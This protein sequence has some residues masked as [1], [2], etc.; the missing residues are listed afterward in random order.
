MQNRFLKN[1]SANTVQLIINQLFG[2]MIFYAL[3]KWFDKNTFGNINWALAVLLTAFTILSFGID[4]VIVQKIAAGEDK[5]TIFSAY[6]FHVI[7][8]GIFF[9]AILLL[10]YF[11]LPGL[12]PQQT[13]LLFLGIGKLFVFFSTPY[14][15]MVTGLEKFRTLLYMSIGSN[16][17][18]G[19]GLIMLALLKQLSLTNV[20]IIFIAGDLIEFLL[21][22][23]LVKKVEYFPQK[24][25]FNRKSHLQLVK[26]SLPQ[27]GIEL[28]AAIMSR[29]DWI[30]I[31]L[32]I[33]SSKLAEYSFASKVFE[34]STLPLLIIQT[35]LLPLFT[36]VLN[37]KV[38][39]A[40]P[41]PDIA[42]LL[43]WKII[44]ASFIALVLYQVW[45]PA[46]DFFTDGKYGAINIH[47]ILIFSASMPLLY[48][49][50][51]LWTINFATG[52]M[53]L[54]FFI[55]IIS[56][57]VNVIFCLILIPVWQNEGAALA[58]FLSIFVQS[59]LY[60]YK[61][62]F[63]MTK[64]RRLRLLIWPAIAFLSGYIVDVNIANGFVRIIIPAVIFLLGIFVLK[65][66]RRRDWK[67]LHTMYQ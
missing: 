45:T 21:C 19:T 37:R 7:L 35:V 17:V 38:D 57:I 54:I 60:L 16:I 33:T 31:G 64:G 29:F 55:M 4:K 62:G 51:Y 20:I 47:V 9:Y 50:N 63:S 27:A 39:V 25:L 53:K 34:V 14:K 48:L 42:F 32:I 12:F 6:V 10:S 8:T 59:V 15:Q 13:M 52:K 3:S 23:L 22:I 43:E 30:L 40:A 2:L 44:I 5:S 49:N 41:L 61:T 58:L 66:F 18:R 26:T 56:L 67:T 28:F 1:I 65:Q 46:I 36:R 24:I 11:L